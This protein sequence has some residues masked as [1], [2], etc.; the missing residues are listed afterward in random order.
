MVERV[1]RVSPRLASGATDVINDLRCELFLV[2]AEFFRDELATPLPKQRGP[3][4][5]A[6][7]YPSAS[8]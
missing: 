6:Y 7:S 1:L 8:R 5:L 2:L 4:S 3:T